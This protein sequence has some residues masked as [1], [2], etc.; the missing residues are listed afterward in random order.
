MGPMSAQK[1]MKAACKKINFLNVYCN[2]LYTKKILFSL[3][4]EPK[5]IVVKN[6]QYSIFRQFFTHF[7]FFFFSLFIQPQLLLHFF[8]P[9]SFFVAVCLLLCFYSFFPISTPC[10]FSKHFYTFYVSYVSYF[11]LCFVNKNTRYTILY[12]EQKKLSVFSFEKKKKKISQKN[13]I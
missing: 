1:L 10:I 4:P 6:V 13:H 12:T 11:F 8:F 5:R 7:Y 3:S 9:F 2:R